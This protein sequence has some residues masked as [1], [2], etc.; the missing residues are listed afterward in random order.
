MYG[1][2]SSLANLGA[3]GSFREKKQHE[4]LL[5]AVNVNKDSLKIFLYIFL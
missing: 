5:R 1:E 4:V 3:I 2:L